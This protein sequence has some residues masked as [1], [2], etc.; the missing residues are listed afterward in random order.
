M[1]TTKKMTFSI[2]QVNDDGV[3]IMNELKSMLSD[4]NF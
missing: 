3:K 1:M 4:P 2:S